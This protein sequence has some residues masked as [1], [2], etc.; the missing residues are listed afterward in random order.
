AIMRNDDVIEYLCFLALHRKAG[1]NLKGSVGLDFERVFI[2]DQ[3]DRLRI[4]QGN[5]ELLAQN[6]VKLETADKADRF[7]AAG[8]HKSV[9]RLINPEHFLC[10]ADQRLRWYA[11]GRLN[12]RFYAD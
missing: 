6:F 7:F 2:H 12:K 4:K 9:Y 10:I 8:Y 5:S 3:R 1:G 11:H